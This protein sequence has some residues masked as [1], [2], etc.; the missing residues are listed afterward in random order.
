MK[1]Q[2]VYLV[3]MFNEK[4]DEIRRNPLLPSEFHL[5]KTMLNQEDVDSIEITKHTV[6][7]EKQY[8]IDNQLALMF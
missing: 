2:K 6:T 3:K 1:T 8:E 5:A 7:G 4:G